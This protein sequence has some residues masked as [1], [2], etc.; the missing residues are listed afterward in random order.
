MKWREGHWTGDENALAA[1]LGRPNLDPPSLAPDIIIRN[2]IFGTLVRHTPSFCIPGKAA[3][4]IAPYS[5]Y[6]SRFF[7]T[8]SDAKL[9]RN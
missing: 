8:A 1:S 5:I 2:L 7:F 9:A 3:A 4:K 6:H